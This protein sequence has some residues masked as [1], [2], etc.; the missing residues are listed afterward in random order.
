M[1]ATVN[2]NPGYLGVR[3]EQLDDCGV[4]IVEIVTDSPA[5]KAKLQADDVI[6]ALDGTATPA[7][8]L[9]RQSI[10][11]KQ[12]GD[13]VTLTVQRS[14]QQMDIEVTLGVRPADS[15]GTVSVPTAAATQ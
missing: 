10:Q 9:L 2:T 6:V 7:I 11:A 14:G 1:A 13:K 4:L 5:D 15:T 12:P 8:A 3:A